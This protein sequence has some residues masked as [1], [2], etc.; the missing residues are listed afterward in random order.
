MTVKTNNRSN[1]IL[2]KTLFARLLWWISYSPNQ[3]KQRKDGTELSNNGNSKNFWSQSSEGDEMISINNI[4]K[5]MK[6][7]CKQIIIVNVY[8]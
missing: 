2:K 6:P 5:N 1:N 4:H 7:T 3:T 8:S